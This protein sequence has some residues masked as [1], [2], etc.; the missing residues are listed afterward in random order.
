MRHGSD[1]IG[2]N[3]GQG[4]RKI[5]A[6]ALDHPDFCTGDVGGDIVTAGNRNQW[7]FSTVHNERRHADRLQQIAAMIAGQEGRQLARHPARVEAALMLLGCLLYTSR[8]V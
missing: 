6:H 8:C 3:V 5:M 4:Q 7:V 2:E 1:G